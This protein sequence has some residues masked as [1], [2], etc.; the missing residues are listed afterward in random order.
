MLEVVGPHGFPTLAGVDFGH[1]MPNIPLP[2]GARAGLDADERRL[3]IT[4]AAV[5]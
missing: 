4:E 5:G 1:N 3:S 2:I